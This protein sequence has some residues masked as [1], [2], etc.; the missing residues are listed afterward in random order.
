MLL[1]KE[2]QSRALEALKD[3]FS[4]CKKCGSTDTAFY[5]TTGKWIGTKLPYNNIVQMAG[6]PYVCIRIPTGGGKTLVACHAVGIAQKELL[7]A[8]KSVI[9]W[10][11]PSN[12]IKEQTI[13]ALKDNNHPYRQAVEKSIGQVEV[14]DIQQ[15][16]YLKK[17]IFLGQNVII[18]STMQA[19]RVEETEGRK[20]YVQSGELQE[21]F[22]NIPPLKSVDLECYSDSFEYIRYPCAWAITGATWRGIAMNSDR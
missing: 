22:V 15:A 10:L 19:F 4:A 6:L 8:D 20:V 17:A 16:L 14:M 18:V 5:E 1:L 21:H 2:Y 3:Y 13:N 7:G 9:L 11:V 12:T